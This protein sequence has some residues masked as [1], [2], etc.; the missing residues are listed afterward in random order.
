MDM[1]H[2][3]EHLCYEVY[4]DIQLIFLCSKICR[5][6]SIRDETEQ[7]EPKEIIVVLR[8]WHETQEIHM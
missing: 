2:C 6:L 4:D 7:C 3:I 5:Y 1:Q 8:Q